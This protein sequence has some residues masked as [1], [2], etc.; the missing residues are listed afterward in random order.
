[1]IA[2]IT[3]NREKEAEEDIAEWR[4]LGELQEITDDRIAGMTKN[5]EQES[6]SNE[7]Y[8]HQ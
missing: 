1:M 5:H 7:N 2:D 8:V 3:E 4:N 6:S